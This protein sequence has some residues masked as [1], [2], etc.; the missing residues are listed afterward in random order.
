MAVN[1]FIGG[2][3]CGITGTSFQR[4]A[5]NKMGKAFPIYSMVIAPPNCS[6][7]VINRAKNGF[8]PAIMC[9]GS[10]SDQH[11]SDYITINPS[12]VGER[13]ASDGGELSNESRKSAA[14]SQSCVQNV[15]LD[16]IMLSLPAIAGQAIE[17]MAQL[18]ETAYI[19][20]LGPL[21]LASAGVSTSIFN[22]LSK[23][24]N[25]PLLSVATS[26]VAEDISRSSSKDS[27]SDSSCPNVSYNGCDESTDRKLLPS[28]STALVL[29]L[30]IGILEA[31][32]M[33][34]GSGLFLDIMGI[35]SA[36][37]MRIP[38]QRFLSLRAIGAPAVVLSLAIQGIFRG[39]K[40][41]RT[42]VFCLGLGN[43]SAVFMFPM[44]MYYFK[45]GVTGAAI[46]T[47]GSQYMVTLLMIWY[48]NKRTILSIPN[49][50]NLHFGDYLR[51]GG[52]LLGRTLA[53]VM[54]ITLSTSIAARQGA[55]AMAAHQ[56]CLQVWLSV[57]MLA[58]AQAASGQALIAS[59]FAKGDYNTVKE[60]T[61]FA[62]KTG[63]FTGVTLA[64]ILGAS[65]NYLATLF[66][67]DTQV[68]GIVRSGLLF[69]SASQPV[70]AVAYIFDGLHY[71]V[72]DFSYAAYSMMAV[73]AISSVFLLYAPRVFGLS[74]VW[75]GL[76]LFMSLRVVAGYFRLLSK[77]GPWWFLQKHMPK[78]E[79]AN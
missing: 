48:L 71:G 23:V 12:G 56:I 36:S 20:R 1:Q 38:A 26:F 79:I 14:T 24:F 16:L 47:V 67:S 28:V 11:A 34:F 64:V 54:T 10:V 61:H 51:S 41:T 6:F 52:Y 78:L 45:L 58:D 65:F 3:S 31:L 42:P 66:T 4:R 5:I 75:W 50:K 27:T 22:I 15:Q 40:D 68:L 21:E 29:A 8:N 17:P 44:L 39:F 9:C 35:S 77:N 32:A 62:L 70:T 30:T 63:L 13:L 2:R 69:V 37:S 19:G 46:S 18:M 53:A 43:F 60:I 72:S 33:Y 74:A 57:S 55:L 25:I 59:S 76:T 49:M 73:G 7:G